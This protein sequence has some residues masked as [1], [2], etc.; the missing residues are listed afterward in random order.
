MALSKRTKPYVRILGMNERGKG[1]LSKI[2]KENP[3]LEVITSV[4]KFSDSSKDKATKQLLE[5][6]IRATDVYTL[7]YQKTSLANMD[8]TNNIIIQK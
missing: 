7:A 2:T 6:D 8:Y 3:K 4:K 5:I 1:L